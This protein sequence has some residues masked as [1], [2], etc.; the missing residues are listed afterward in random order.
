MVFGLG[1]VLLYAQAAWV[2]GSANPSIAQA[3]VQGITRP[4]LAESAPFGTATGL[5]AASLDAYINVLASV[6]GATVAVDGETRGSTGAEIAVAPGQRIVRVEARG[7]RAWQRSLDLDPEEHLALDIDLGASWVDAVRN[8]TTSPLAIIVENEMHARPQAGL[9]RADIVYEALA[10]GGIT[11]F[12]AVYASQSADVIGPVRSARD[13]FVEWA[14]E[15][16]APLVHIGASPQGYAA[17]AATRTLDLDEI[18]GQPGF[19]RSSERPAP[20]NAYTSTD[21]AR[22]ALGSRAVAKGSYSGL[23]FADM[24]LARTGEPATEATIRFGGWKYT[25][26]WTYEPS[27]NEYLRDMDDEPHLDAETGEQLRATNVLLEWVDSWLIPGDREG[28]LEFASV[29]SGRV[30]LL[31]DGVAVEG[32]WQKDSHEAPTKYVTEDGRPLLLNPGP[33]WIE[34]IPAAGSVTF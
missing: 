3:F 18:K 10:E 20:H 29:G 16:T 5:S 26:G 21:G 19:W 9:D 11:R 7:Y 4:S 27:S 17:I 13:Y 8:G 30:V 12:L 32:R 15:Y 6:P 14:H 28:R 22:G 2:H 33:T 34:V 31:V 25:A 23:R 24:P 1:G